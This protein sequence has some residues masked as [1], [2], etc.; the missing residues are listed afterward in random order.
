MYDT[1][2]EKQGKDWQVQAYYDN[3]FQRKRISQKKQI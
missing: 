1:S 2:K 3:R